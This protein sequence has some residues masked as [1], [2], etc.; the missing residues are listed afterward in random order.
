[1][2]KTLFTVISLLL[3]A[4]CLLCGCES[5][6][7]ESDPPKVVIYNSGYQQDD[8]QI[9]VFGKA[10]SGTELPILRIDSKEAMDSFNQKA[11]E[12]F[13]VDE[14]GESDELA[15][16]TDY[17]EAVS[18]Y[19]DEFFEEKVLIACFAYASHS[20]ALFEVNDIS[21]KD[22]KLTVIVESMAMSVD[23][24]MDGCFIFIELPKNDLKGVTE[25][26]ANL[27]SEEMA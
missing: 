21:I 12:H 17:D 13:Y 15:A 9:A 18:P 11:K 16:G 22:G 2:K 25:L 5:A 26:S 20:P 1:M 24:L 14:E 23:Y 19:T 4:A 10:A 6:L 27:N 3:T 7:A 8:Q